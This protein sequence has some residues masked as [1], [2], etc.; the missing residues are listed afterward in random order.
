MPLFAWYSIVWPPCAGQDFVAFSFVVTLGHTRQS[1][2]RYS[3]VVAVR[4]T[5]ANTNKAYLLHL[6]A[7]PEKCTLLGASKLYFIMSATPNPWAWLGLLKWSL[8]YADGTRPSDLSPMTKKDRDFLEAVMKDGIIDE[9]ERMKVI[10]Q[11]V[12]EKLEVWKDGSSMPAGN[13]DE[14]IE[15]L[16]LELRDIV[17]QIDYAR[18]FMALRG[19]PFLLG[20]IQEPSVPLSVR[21]EC[22]GIIATMAHNNPPVQKE[23]LE[24][25][26]LKILSDMFF[27][28]TEQSGFQARLIQ[29]MSATVRQHALAE[30]VFCQLEQA[31]PLFE[32]ALRRGG[33]KILHKRAMFFLAALLTSDDS[34][35]ERTSRFSPIIA[36]VVDQYLDES[37]SS[38]TREIALSLTEQL[39][40]RD[41]LPTNNNQLRQGIAAK[42][43]S[44]I[45]ALR[46]LTGEESEGCAVELQSWEKILVSLAQQK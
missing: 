2:T 27:V 11:Q 4:R 28:N 46:L 8:S 24:T 14:A 9:N 35:A 19:L 17:E 15:T 30:A 26:A 20:C 22:C 7:R 10:L 34:D 25:G 18:A 5:I 6:Q 29:A 16:L 41:I 45:Q 23:L 40:E 3:L 44:R 32:S 13:G 38:E 37:A 36:L 33:S 39:I 31:L 42:G 21:T 12:T 1:T 43:V